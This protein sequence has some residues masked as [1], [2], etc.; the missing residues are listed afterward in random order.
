MGQQ[1]FTRWGIEMFNLDN[2]DTWFSRILAEGS[3]R[4]R[5]SDWQCWG[6]SRWVVCPAG[7][8]EVPR[9]C[10]SLDL[11]ARA[12]LQLWPPGGDSNSSSPATHNIFHFREINNIWLTSL[13][14]SATYM[15]RDAWS[16]PI[17]CRKYYNFTHGLGIARVTHTTEGQF[18][19]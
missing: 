8:P 18:I 1:R 5:G 13:L 14:P 2:I 4:H 12:R 3:H 17:D 11:E 10:P 15:R 9:T 16:N 7:Y 6:W 19:Q